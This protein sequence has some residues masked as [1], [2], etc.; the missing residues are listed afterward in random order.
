MGR[1]AAAASDFQLREASCR[2]ENIDRAG[3]SEGQKKSGSL[4]YHQAAGVI[5]IPTKRKTVN[6]L[7]SM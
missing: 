1:S 6:R 5:C 3:M 2:V 4:A 7:L